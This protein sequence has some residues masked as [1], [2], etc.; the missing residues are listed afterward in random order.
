M[1]LVTQTGEIAMNYI[2]KLRWKV[3]IRSRRLHTRLLPTAPWRFLNFLNLYLRFYSILL[4]CLGLFYLLFFFEC[5]KIP[6]LRVGG[7][8]VMSGPS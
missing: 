7:F 3:L 2:N 1:P 6:L 8:H 4:I 5:R